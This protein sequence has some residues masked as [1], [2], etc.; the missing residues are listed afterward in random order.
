MEIKSD[1]KSKNLHSLLTHSPQI[2]AAYCF[3]RP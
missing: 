3:G 1:T 2:Q